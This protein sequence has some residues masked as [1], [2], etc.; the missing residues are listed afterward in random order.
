MGVRLLARSTGAK[1][2]RAAVDDFDWQHSRKQ[3][4]HDDTHHSNCAAYLPFSRF[5]KPSQ[6]G[7]LL[8]IDSPYL[9]TSKSFRSSKSL[10][11]RSANSDSGSL[12]RYSSGQSFARSCLVKA[13]HTPE[14]QPQSIPSVIA[15]P[16]FRLPKFEKRSHIK[17]TSC[18]YHWSWRGG[19]ED[20]EDAQSLYSPQ[21]LV[22]ERPRKG[23]LCSTHSTVVHRNI[24]K[25]VWNT[26]HQCS[27]PPPPSLMLLPHVVFPT[28]QTPNAEKGEHPSM[29]CATQ[30]NAHHAPP[31]PIHDKSPIP[32]APLVF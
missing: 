10:L 14:N 18:T 12:T 7:K 21:E 28:P 2:R 27:P 9:P 20:P 6:T 31:P 29:L 19:A 25:S 3:W 13:G 24:H 8:V 11:S 26:A 1:D 5:K 23:S 30:P 16:S 17:S 4:L 32:L 22:Q 15:S